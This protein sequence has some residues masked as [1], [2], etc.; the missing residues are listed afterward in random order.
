MAQPL[1]FIIG[2]SRGGVMKKEAVVCFFLVFL[3]LSLHSAEYIIKTK[4][5]NLRKLPDPKSEVVTK[6][7]QY[8]SVKI[9]AQKG[10][11]FKVKNMDG[12][13]GWVHKSAV[14]KLAD[15]EDEKNTTPQK[16]P[17]QTQ[18]NFQPP[19]DNKSTSQNNIFILQPQSQT[20]TA[21]PAE[22]QTLVSS[23]NKDFSEKKKVSVF[24]LTKRRRVIGEHIFPTT[25]LFPTPVPSARFGFSQG[26]L[27]KKGEYIG[28]TDDNEDGVIQPDEIS[29]NK[30]NYA[31]LSEIFDA[32]I[33]IH[34]NIAIDLNANIL[35]SGGMEKKDFM[36]IEATPGGDIR[37][38]PV[39]SHQ[40][41]NNLLLSFAP[42]YYISKGIQISASYGIAG[43]FDQL[44][45]LFNDPGF[46]K[47]YQDIAGEDGEINSIDEF[48]EI[49][50]STYVAGKLPDAIRG[51]TKNIMVNTSK[52]AL[53]PSVGIAYPFTDYLGVQAIIEYQKVK[54]TAKT[55][56]F[57]LEEKY[58]K[59]N[60]GLA[61]SLDCR[62]LFSFPLGMGVEYFREKYKIETLNNYALGIYYQ[63][64][65]DIQLGLNLKIQKSKHKESDYK[66]SYSQ[67]IMQFSIIYFF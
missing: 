19:V 64:I 23:S 6:L 38:G 28:I 21:K 58:S 34:K 55:K 49:I 16:T 10:N 45:E 33:V 57:S 14:E 47:F 20:Q 29:S 61:A 25:V 56:S 62:H 11:W 26:F 18:T 63:G 36:T 60:Y 22:N 52:T 30:Y 1:S 2:F 40:F 43:M 65:G 17:E 8:E 3:N 53:S 15:E 39:F 54:E 37:I 42:R 51:F 41:D 66:D 32:G 4:K 27:T 59:L 35:L 12:Y 48:F 46:K 5:A 13:T 7:Y 44:N 31:G 50:S 9:I 67:R 24:D